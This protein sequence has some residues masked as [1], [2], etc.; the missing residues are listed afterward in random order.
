M[1]KICLAAIPI[2]GAAGLTS[3]LALSAGAQS[4]PI[5]ELSAFGCY[6]GTFIDHP[7]PQGLIDDCRAL[8]A[9]HEIW[10]RHPDNAGLAPDDPLRQWGKGD[11]VPITSWVGVGIEN[12]R[13]SELRMSDLAGPIPPHIGNLT[14]LEVLHLRGNHSGAIPAELGQLTNL[15]LLYLRS[16]KLTGP[17]PP[18]LGNLTKLHTMNLALNELTGPIPAEF[19]QLTN[20]TAMH[21][22]ANKLSGPL[23]HQLGQLTNLIETNMS[24]N[25]LSGP[26]PIE[27]GQMTNLRMLILR[28][29]RLTGP[30]PKELS[31]LTNLSILD[32]G[33]NQL[34][35]TIPTQ[36]S[37][38]SN[39]GILYLDYNNLSGSI[40]YQ[41]GRM[42]NLSAIALTG[43]NLTGPLPKQLSRITNLSALW[44]GNNRLTG[45]IPSE[46][47][48]LTNLENLDLDRNRL[49]GSIPTQL[50]QLTKLQTL[51][52]FH[53]ELTGGI[54]PQ[55]SQL[56]DL[57]W[58]WLGCNQLTGAIPH[59]LAQIPDLNLLNLHPNQLS[60]AVSME[61]RD[62]L[63]DPA[64]CLKPVGRF[65]DDDCREHEPYIEYVAAERIMQ[66]CGDGRFCPDDT[67]TRK[68][69]A[70]FLYRAALILEAF[71]GQV[72]WILPN[73]I[74]DGDSEELYQHYAEWAVEQKI[75]R[76]PGGEFNPD[77][78][79]TR[80]E[81]AEMIASIFDLITPDA[82]VQGLF[83]D[84][85]NQPD[86]VVRAAEALKAASIS[87]GCATAP[88]RYCPGRLI[89]RG[90]TAALL[91]QALSLSLW[92]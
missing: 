60:G 86:R 92:A 82:K 7:S 37:Q 14:N 1:K 42:T 54:P 85:S 67:I 31:Q 12:Q 18:Q 79:V 11:N 63:L 75:M 73:E 45:T 84:M 34:V 76:A 71:P 33:V 47:S 41:L 88:L 29:N 4:N 46:L 61:L 10:A 89:T 66:G 59:E 43:N 65:S 20:L 8:V 62:L 40:P 19:G 26:I 17:I 6:N 83:A 74:T 36:L 21:L 28:G 57:G 3:A 13:V 22:F 27:L 72:S 58:L 25:R 64:G 69:T 55:L 51:N 30:I 9:A 78:M 48:Q 38:L 52:L 39:L 68:Q 81:M 35:G 50:S 80:A 91:T 16:N 53:N 5:P 23:P 56:A 24:A 70:A 49:T 2:L 87:N 77:G 44:L 90:Q 32:L 15:K